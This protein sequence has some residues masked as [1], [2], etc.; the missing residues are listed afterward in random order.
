MT[1]ITENV[2]IAANA[3]ILP[4]YQPVNLKLKLLKRHYYS[5]IVLKVPLNPNQSISLCP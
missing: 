2:T 5:V 3:T 1:K 4:I